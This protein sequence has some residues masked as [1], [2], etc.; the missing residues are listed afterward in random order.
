MRLD[1]LLKINIVNTEYSNAKSVFHLLN[2]LGL[3]SSLAC[4]TSEVNGDALI[5][6]GVGSAKP[7]MKSLK[8]RGFDDVVKE[9]HSKGKLIIGICLGYQLLTK[10]TAED[11]GVSGF[12]LINAT[13]LPISQVARKGTHNGWSK[14]QI[15]KRFCAESGYD[16]SNKKCRK[17]VA[18]GRTYYN[19]EYGVLAHDKKGHI[20]ISHDTISNFSAFYVRENIVGM[21][22]H[23]EKSQVFG[24]GL[25]ELLLK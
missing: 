10:V 23:P 18:R 21:Q 4:K 7:Y 1:T 15:S 25:M 22:F 19:H 8:S 6:P 20:P 14:I 13:C 3:N 5:L 17:L 24:L 2:L 12:N 16:F 9:F 11:G